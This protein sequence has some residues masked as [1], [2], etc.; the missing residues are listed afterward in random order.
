MA[1]RVD[2]DDDDDDDYVQL[3]APYRASWENAKTA[4]EVRAVLGAFEDAPPMDDAVRLTLQRW[5]YRQDKFLGGGGAGQITMVLRVFLESEVNRDALVEPI[6]SAVSWAKD[7]A[8]AKHG[9]A[10]LDAFDQIKLTELLAT[11][12]GL[13][14]FS[15]KSICSYLSIAIRNKVTKILEPAEAKPAPLSKAQIMG[16]RLALGVALLKL[17]ADEPDRFGALAHE[18]FGIDPKS[19]A[20]YRPMAVAA[21]Y[22]N[23]PEITSR[24]SWTALCALSAPTL[25]AAVRRKFEKAIMTGQAVR[26]PH[27]RRARQA[28]A[29]RRPA[30]QPAPRMAASPC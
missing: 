15:E 24:I 18:R 23:R 22:A 28:H 27:V 21:L 8:F 29:E 11:M 10:L 6:L 4:A 5:L 13:D 7:P 16:D 14:V 25:P 12:R 20:F 3:A 17:K 9:L 2:D 30:D 1:R 19:E 26:E